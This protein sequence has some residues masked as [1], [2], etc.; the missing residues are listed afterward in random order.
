[1]LDIKRK[2]LKVSGESGQGVNSIGEI[3][4]KA[5]KESGFYT[6]G[7]REYPSLIKGGYACHQIDFADRPLTSSSIHTDLLV[8]LSRVSFHAYLPTVRQNGQIIHM[9]R[10][11]ELTQT[12]QELVKERNLKIAYIP[13][14]VVATEAGGKAIMA[15]IVMVGALW[16]LLGLPIGPLEATVKAEFARKPDMIE[17]N[18][19]CLNQGHTYR[20]EGLEPLKLNFTIV[21]QREHDG[22]LTGNH[23][24]ALGSV[25]A[26]V[27]AYFAYPMT[28]SS[29]ILSY[30]ANIYKETGMLVK[31]VE[32]EI[33]VAQ[34]AIGAMF[35]GTRALVGTSG[36]GYDLMTESVSM[37][38]MT[39]TPFV[40]ILA[41]RPGPATGLPTWTA[42]ADLHLAVFAA[43]GEF[44]RCVIAASD[45]ASTY[46]VVQKAF[47]IAEKYQIPVIVLTDK[48]IAESLFQLENLPPDLPIERHLVPKEKLESL[49]PSDRYKMT[50]TG[51]SPR[52]LPGQSDAIFDANSDEHVADG[53]LTEE[54]EAS[55]LMYE[56][57]LK[58]QDVLLAELPEPTLIGPS[59]AWM[60]FVGWGSVRNT[61]QDVMA[62]WNEEYPDKQINYLH[63]EFVYP[64]KTQQLQA[65]IT[66]K[67][68]LVLIE[69][70]ALGQL[71]SL[72]SQATG[73]QFT[74][75]VLK[76]DGRGFFVEDI[77]RYLETKHQ[78][79][80]Q[81]VT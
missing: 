66:Q 44:A 13:A 32:D 36:G 21:P 38:A 60:T 30:L 4:A 52:W 14:E 10:S 17:P 65:L 2:V 1:M 33:S 61:V 15:N 28:P 59:K 55:R 53:S 69:N 20:L 6:F 73:F 46:L 37:A 29:S 56:K 48:Q 35:A 78:T 68:Q 16:Q 24:I 81:K 40:C 19:K 70:N 27:R 42:A 23:L 72:I 77:L 25:A 64:L 62:L 26:G 43:H 3:L 50:E 12:E 51:I 34:M 22:L 9:L 54:A 79:N 75:R 74:E 8:C 11:L 18:I 41:Q 57:R 39:E 47:N 5:M 63:Y 76:Y 49:E 7:Y 31:Q 67:T 58:K 45:P 80:S 71:G